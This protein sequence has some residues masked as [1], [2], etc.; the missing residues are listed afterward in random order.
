MRGV[1]FNFTPTQH[2]SARGL[3]DR[4]QTL[5]GGFAVFAPDL[6]GYFAGDTGYLK[7]FVDV[8]ARFSSRQ[9]QAQPGLRSRA[10]SDWGLQTVL[11]HG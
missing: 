7:D 4:S 1:P 5:W 10:A 6:H 3:G 8:R 11:V 2:W 9:R